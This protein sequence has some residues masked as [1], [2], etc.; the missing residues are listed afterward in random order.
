MRKNNNNGPPPPKEAREMVDTCRSNI[1]RD[2]RNFKFASWHTTLAFYCSLAPVLIPCTRLQLLVFAAKVAISWNLAL[3]GNY[4]FPTSK[5]FHP[6][7]CMLLSQRKLI[8]WFWKSITFHWLTRCW[9]CCW[10][11][12][13]SYI[14]ITWPKHAYDCSPLSGISLSRLSVGGPGVVSNVVFVLKFKCFKKF[15]LLIDSFICWLSGWLIDSLIFFIFFCNQKLSFST[16]KAFT[17]LW[18]YGLDK[19]QFDKIKDSKIAIKVWS[20]QRYL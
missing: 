17:I 10:V 20:A 4:R 12:T 19:M 7:F 2:K 8:K 9:I 11:N 14:F 16:E 3:D 13:A 15:G 6:Q 18:F 1:F 5:I